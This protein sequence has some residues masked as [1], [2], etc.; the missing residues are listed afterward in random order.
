MPFCL[1]IWHPLSKA[2]FHNTPYKRGPFPP[3]TAAAFPLVS[4]GGIPSVFTPIG[5]LPEGLGI[6]Y[7]E[8]R[9]VPWA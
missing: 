8:G 4:H 1:L 5:I 6:H 7:H 3:Q 9:L 2:S